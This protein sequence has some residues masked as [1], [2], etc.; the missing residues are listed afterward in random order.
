MTPPDPNADPSRLVAVFCDT[1]AP[2]TVETVETKPLTA[3]AGDD[4]VVITCD[5]RAQPLTDVS[6]CG[7]S[8]D[9][10][11]PMT[12]STDAVQ[13]AGHLSGVPSDLP[14]QIAVGPNPDEA[15]PMTVTAVGGYDTGTN[16]TTLTVQRSSSVPHAVGEHLRFE[17]NVVDVRVPQGAD[18]QTDDDLLLTLARHA[19]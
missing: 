13:I 8:A 14:Y 4:P 17:P 5:D 19:S 9:L 11:A 3:W 12:T 18:G 10:A 15:E 7:G 1:V 2:A 16:T 6:S